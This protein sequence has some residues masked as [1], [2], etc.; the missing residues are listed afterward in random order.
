LFV[1]GQ[2]L[3]DS[4]NNPPVPRSA[5]VPLRRSFAYWDEVT[6]KWTALPGAYN[7][8]VS[9]ASDDIKL[10]GKFSL[11]NTLTADP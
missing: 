7:A 10:N 3:I 11:P 5:T 2:K 1:N 6:Q 9:A 8:L 4:F